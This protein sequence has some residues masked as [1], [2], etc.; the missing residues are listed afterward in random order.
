LEGRLH[1]PFSVEFGNC[2][3]LFDVAGLAQYP[4]IV[5]KNNVSL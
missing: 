2:F 4:F 5:G 1:L 3:G